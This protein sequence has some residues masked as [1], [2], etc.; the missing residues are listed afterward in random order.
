M[1]LSDVIKRREGKII[2][3]GPDIKINKYWSFEMGNYWDTLNRRP[4]KDFY[5]GLKFKAKW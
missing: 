5:F 3:K 2:I 1:N 4:T